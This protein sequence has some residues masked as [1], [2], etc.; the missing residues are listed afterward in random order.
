[1][2]FKNAREND[3]EVTLL[4]SV[5]SSGLIVPYARLSEDAH[6]ARDA[7]RFAEAKGK[8]DRVLDAALLASE[9]WDTI[10]PGSWR[11]GELCD[12][13]GDPDAWDLDT[14]KPVSRKKKAR[15]I[16]KVLRNALAHGNVFTRGRP[17]IDTLVFL[18][19]RC[20]KNPE[21]G[22]NCVLVSPADLK[23]FVLNWLETLGGVEVG[24]WVFVE[25][26]LLER[27]VA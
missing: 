8:L 19:R 17:H 4:L 2:H 22:Y 20:Q 3:L 12:L 13:S 26:Q 6:P 21:Q 18:S 14:L 15:S 7:D 1:M 5:A 24:G 16:V 10:D 9:L 25:G 11:F 23:C 27:A